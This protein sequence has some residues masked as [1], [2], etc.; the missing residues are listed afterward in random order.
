MSYHCDCSSLYEG[1]LCELKID[2]CKNETCSGNGNCIDFNNK[3]KCVCFS[4]YEGENCE[5]VN[6]SLKI[7]KQVISIASI[8]AICFLVCFYLMIVLLDI[9]RIFWIKNKVSIKKLKW[10]KRN[11]Q[12]NYNM[13]DGMKRNK[14]IRKNK[15]TLL[16]WLILWLYWTIIINA[17][18]IDIS[19]YI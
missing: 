6:E 18:V 9:L 14:K 7:T 11:L 13:N 17:M 2:V 15:L 8:I 1:S 5:T 16:A 4:S 12:Q 19:V 3:P 10:N